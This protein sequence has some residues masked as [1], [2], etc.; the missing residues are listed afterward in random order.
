MHPSD[1]HPLIYVVDVLL[2]QVFSSMLFVWLEDLKPN[3][4]IQ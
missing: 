2:E 4:Q 1:M 3:I